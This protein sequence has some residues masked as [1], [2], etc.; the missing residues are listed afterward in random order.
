MTI[1]NKAFTGVLV[2]GDTLAMDSG[3]K[4]SKLAEKSM[5]V[6]DR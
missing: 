2:T 1:S 4:R 3:N 5:R 6:L